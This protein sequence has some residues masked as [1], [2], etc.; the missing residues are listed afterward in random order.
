MYKIL[1]ANE[2]PVVRGSPNS[3]CFWFPCNILSGRISY[4]VSGFAGND[5][6]SF[7]FPTAIATRGGVSGGGG[8]GSGRPA[9]ANK[10]SYLTGGSGSGGALA[11][12]RGTE[13]L[14]F[15]IGDE[16]LAAAAGP[17]WS[18]NWFGSTEELM[19]YRLWNTLPRAA[20]PGGELGMSL[21]TKMRRQVVDF[22][23]ITWN[24]SGQT[25]Y[26]NTY[27]SNLKTTISS[28]QN[29]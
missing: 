23:R 7:V 9:V 29:L 25:P 27:G 22:S 20:W 24:G 28:S 17:G 26:S 5:A 10:P 1:A 16:A 18:S 3:V 12:K 15:S 6:P 2:V 21:P 4:D 11:A 13:D 8:S 14:D 19:E